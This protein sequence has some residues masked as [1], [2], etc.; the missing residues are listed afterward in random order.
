M[1]VN[2]AE[3]LISGAVAILGISYRGKVG[4]ISDIQQTFNKHSPFAYLN[5]DNNIHSS[6]TTTINKKINATCKVLIPCFMS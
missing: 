4:F 3:K 5:V 2:E 6:Q 1:M